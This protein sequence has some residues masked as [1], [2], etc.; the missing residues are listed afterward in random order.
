MIK[1]SVPM[2]GSVWKVL[3]NVGDQVA[4]GQEL[5]I[6]ESMKM[7]VPIESEV[8]GTVVEIK[9]VIGE[10]VNEGDVIVVLQ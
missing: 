5:V 9:A 4:I 10:F 7:E 6:L 2:A 1:V 3:I 8:N